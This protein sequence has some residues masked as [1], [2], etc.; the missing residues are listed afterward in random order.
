MSIRTQIIHFI[1]DIK[2]ETIV[3]DDRGNPRLYLDEESAAI[4]AIEAFGEDALRKGKYRVQGTTARGYTN[5]EADSEQEVSFRGT[6]RFSDNDSEA[7]RHQLTDGK[8]KK[9]RK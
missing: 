5:E 4:A 8:N 2:N 6:R 1:Y 9:R 7:P 3:V